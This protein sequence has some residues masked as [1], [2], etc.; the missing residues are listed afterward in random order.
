MIIDSG[1]P[2]TAGE[3]VVRLI[4]RA[5]H[6][7]KVLFV[8]GKDVSDLTYPLDA[9]TGLLMKASSLARLGAIVDDLVAV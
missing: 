5:V 4:R 6:Q 7:L 9:R 8:T 3:A 2:D 1:L